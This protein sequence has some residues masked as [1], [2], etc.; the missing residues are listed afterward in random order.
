MTDYLPSNT[1]HTHTQIETHDKVASNFL[2][3]YDNLKVRDIYWWLWLGEFGNKGKEKLHI[4]DLLHIVDEALEAEI[5]I[6]AQQ[7]TQVDEADNQKKQV[8]ICENIGLTNAFLRVNLLPYSRSGAPLLKLLQLQD[9]EV[10]HVTDEIRFR[11]NWLLLKKLCIETNKV[12]E[13]LFCDFERFIGFRYFPR[14]EATNDFIKSYGSH[15]RVIYK[16]SF[17]SEFPEYKFI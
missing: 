5:K 8:P 15:F 17:F 11:R 9:K 14:I 16:A 3:S 7:K 13:T 12:D 4:Q 6:E 1:F 2:V 10:Y